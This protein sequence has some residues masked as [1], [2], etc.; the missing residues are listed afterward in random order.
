MADGAAGIADIN[1]II[2]KK[3][4]FRDGVTLDLFSQDDKIGKDKPDDNK[5]ACFI[6]GRNGSG[7]STI[8]QAIADYKANAVDADDIFLDRQHKPLSLSDEARASI[9]VFNETYIS[10]TVQ[11]QDDGLQTIVVL[12][13]RVGI[14][15]E[16]NA[17]ETKIEQEEKT[18]EQHQRDLEEKEN[19]RSLKSY[20]YYMN[21]MIGKLKGDDS[22]AGYDKRIRGNRT[23]TAVTE[24]VVK[25]W[26]TQPAPDRDEEALREA[27]SEALRQLQEAD[28]GAT[29][30]DA[31]ELVNKNT[32]FQ[33]KIEET[34]VRELMEQR[35]EKPELTERDRLI[36]GI[37]QQ[38]PQNPCACRASAPPWS[39]W[40]AH[41]SLKSPRRRSFRSREQS[42]GAQVRSDSRSSCHR[43]T[44]SRNRATCAFLRQRK[45]APRCG[46]A[47]RRQSALCFV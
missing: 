38:Y 20:K 21:R 44:C 7:K 33:T 32:D 25:K 19:P 31:V 27:R 39:L 11:M 3:G 30:V 9:Y 2:L 23:N 14:E 37:M 47:T 35:I 36:M 15:K 6:Y 18:L 45:A 42:P 29:A 40:R 17:L 46:P 43:K 4:I 1:G 12:G 41:R 34:A 16:L 10:D 24:A 28:S 26:A 8:S 13:P 22:W 5:R